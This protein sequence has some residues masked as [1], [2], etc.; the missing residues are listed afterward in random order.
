[1]K[2]TCYKKQRVCTC[3]TRLRLAKC[4]VVEHI[5][6]HMV[7]AILNVAMQKM[8]WQNINIVFKSGVIEIQKR[9]KVFAAV[10]ECCLLLCPIV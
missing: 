3:N 6:I 9:T 2:K 5:M 7:R 1:M 8:L 4:A 10:A